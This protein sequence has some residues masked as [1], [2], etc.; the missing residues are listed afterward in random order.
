MHLDIGND[1]DALNGPP[2]RR[3]VARGGQP[4]RAN[5]PRSGITVCTEP[6]PKLRRAQEEPRGGRPA[7]P[8]RR[9]PLADAEPLL[10]STTSGK[11]GDD[12]AVGLGVPGF[13]RRRYGARAWDTI[14]PLS[15]N[16]LET[17]TAWSSSPPGL[18]RRSSTNPRRWLP[19]C[20]CSVVTACAA[21]LEAC[22]SSWS[23]GLADVVDQA[24]AYHLRV[25]DLAGQIDLDGL[26]DAHALD[27]Q[28]DAGGRDCRASGR[29]LRSG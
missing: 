8:R 4:D 6:L 14:S 11:P 24:L 2:G 26:V 17:A 28:P 9:S 27:R 7:A 19:P 23:A 21:R 22:S 3:V 25:D 29:R 20:C 13:A 16:S 18:L 15:R 12:V 10:T 5:R 1:A